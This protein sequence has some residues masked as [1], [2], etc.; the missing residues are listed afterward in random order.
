MIQKILLFHKI[1]LIHIKKLKNI[2][3]SNDNMKKSNNTNKKKDI[4]DNL[5]QLI[6][7]QCF[8]IKYTAVNYEINKEFFDLIEIE[9][10]GNCF[11]CCISFYLNKN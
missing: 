8:Y 10:Y 5:K 4:K 9:S 7:D 1:K 11:Y 3:N 2:D 6:L